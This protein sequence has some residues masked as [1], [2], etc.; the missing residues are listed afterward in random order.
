MEG[1]ER[2]VRGL[3]GRSS[4]LKYFG[5]KGVRASNNGKGGQVAGQCWQI[6]WVST[7]PISVRRL[8]FRSTAFAFRDQRSHEQGSQS[9]YGATAVLRARAALPF[10]CLLPATHFSSSLLF[11]HRESERRGAI[12]LETKSRVCQE[13]SNRANYVRL[14]MQGRRS[15]ARDTSEWAHP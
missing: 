3:E 9:A 8:T 14:G 6:T 13:R 5:K 15:S 11:G 10:C 12:V 1:R 2:V 4:P 7:T